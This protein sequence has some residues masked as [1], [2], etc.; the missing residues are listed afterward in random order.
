MLPPPPQLKTLYKKDILCSLTKFR[1]NFH[2]P[3][4]DTLQKSPICKP[5][6]LQPKSYLESFSCKPCKPCKPRFSKIFGH[7][8]FEKIFGRDFFEKIFG[9]YFF[10][11]IF[12]Y[13]FFEK[14]F[15]HDFFEKIFGR[16]FFEKIFGRD[17]FG[18]FR[19][20]KVCKVCSPKGTW[21][22]GGGGEDLPW[23]NYR[24]KKMAHWILF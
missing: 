16:D 4:P 15:G 9:R 1:V 8:F 5:C 24:L 7:D 23:Q 12:G 2:P 21:L 22:G 10:E 3:P 6:S 11:K 17:F 13:D 14:I 19:F 20:A 18:W